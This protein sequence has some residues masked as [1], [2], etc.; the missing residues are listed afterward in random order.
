MFSG[1]NILQSSTCAVRVDP[2]ELMA[3][4]SRHAASPPL[5]DSLTSCPGRTSFY[6]TRIYIRATNI[7]PL[8]FNIGAHWHHKLSQRVQEKVYIDTNR[9]KNPHGKKVCSATSPPY[10][11]PFQ[12][13]LLRSHSGMQDLFDAETSCNLRHMRG[14]GHSTIGKYLKSL[15]TV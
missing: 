7:Q 9:I 3:N 6:N 11:P 10:P 4:P 1:K 14:I 2:K 13:Q 8:E 15:Q 12:L 5:E